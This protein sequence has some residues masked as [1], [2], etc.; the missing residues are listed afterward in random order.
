MKTNTMKTNILT[1]VVTLTIGIILVG[2]LLIPVI[3]DASTDDH[4]G[5]NPYYLRMSEIGDETVVLTYDVDNSVN[6]YNGEETNFL[7]S[8]GTKSTDVMIV[9]DTFIACT[10][11]TFWYYYFVYEGN[12]VQIWSTATGATTA[13]ATIGGGSMNLYI[14][15]S[16][17]YDLP[18]TKCYIPNNDGEYAVCQGN[19]KGL[20][21]NTTDILVCTTNRANHGV[22]TGTVNNLT[23]DFHATDGTP[24]TETYVYA[25]V[26]DTETV[27]VTELSKTTYDGY[28]YIIPFEYHYLEENS[29]AGLYSILPVLVIIGLVLAAISVVVTRRD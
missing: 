27:G 11:G 19:T 12:D 9:S 25:V 23:T 24:D 3:A 13:V 21:D 28:K 1:L 26:Y 15:E 20:F 7:N 29:Y 2:S 16:L 14:S 18:Y 17:S 4:T 8:G 6:L 10:T 22:A 5:T